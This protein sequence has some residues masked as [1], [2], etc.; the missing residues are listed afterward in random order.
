MGGARLIEFLHHLRGDFLLIA[1]DHGLDD[2]SVGGRRMLPNQ[3]F[4]APSEPL[5]GEFQ[6]APPVFPQHDDVGR[7]VDVALDQNAAK[8]EVALVVE[9]AGIGEIM[10]TF[11]PRPETDDIP[12]FVGLAGCRVQEDLAFHG[13]EVLILPD[14]EHRDGHR[15][16]LAG[17]PRILRHHAVDLQPSL[18]HMAEDVPWPRLSI[19]VL[20]DRQKGHQKHRRRHRDPQYAV[21]PL[22]PCDQ[23]A[24]EGRDQ[25][26]QQCRI[27]NFL[28]ETRTDSRHGG[29]KKGNKRS[30]H[31]LIC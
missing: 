5:Q 24:G 2:F 20:A 28:Q 10:R 1:Q 26:E 4:Q 21:M 14:A 27:G 12:V 19:K 31:E 11:Q 29:K 22:P 18:L 15:C 7:I 25:G 30:L 23:H 9:P 16:F 8:A 6:R 3:R 13:Q 17:R